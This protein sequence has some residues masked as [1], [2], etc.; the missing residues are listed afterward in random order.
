M[1]LKQCKAAMQPGAPLGNISPWLQ[2][3]VAL[4]DTEDL[5]FTSSFSR[6][7]L[8][9]FSSDRSSYRPLSS[10]SRNNLSLSPTSTF[11]DLVLKKV[12]VPYAKSKQ[13]GAFSSVYSVSLILQLHAPE[14][15][16]LLPP[17]QICPE[18]FRNSHLKLQRQ[19]MMLHT[20]LVLLL[21]YLMK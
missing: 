21:L 15:I 4:S 17:A 5:L 9:P 8:S 6:A 1:S 11:P 3:W 2:G 10:Y 18:C 16:P 12:K 14:L 20:S 13:T 7:P 19:L